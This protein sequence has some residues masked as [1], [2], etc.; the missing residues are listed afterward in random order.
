MFRADGIEILLNEVGGLAVLSCG[1]EKGAN[2]ALGTQHDLAFDATTLLY[3]PH[4]PRSLFNDLFRKNWSVESLRRLVILGNRLDMYDDPYDFSLPL[5]LTRA[6]LILSHELAEPI[7]AP[8]SPPKPP[9]SPRSFP[10]LRS[11]PSHPTAIISMFSTTWH[12]S[13]SLR[14]GSWR[15]P[16]S[17]GGTRVRLAEK[18]GR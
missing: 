2:G 1:E 17:F 16:R 11:S 8:P 18:S 5:R 15:S 6:V 10:F 9:S 12:C 14:N 3:M 7:P 13:G 4:C